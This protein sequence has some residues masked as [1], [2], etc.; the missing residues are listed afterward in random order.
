MDSFVAGFMSK[1]AVDN[2]SWRA[3]VRAAKGGADSSYVGSNTGGY[4]PPAVV[5]SF[6]RNSR[7]RQ[8]SIA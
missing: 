2:G 8:N 4:M 6:Y 5:Q 7:G 1:L 3:A